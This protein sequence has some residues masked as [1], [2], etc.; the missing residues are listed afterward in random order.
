MIPQVLYSR[1]EK[2]FLIILT[3]IL[4]CGMIPLC[5]LVGF[6]IECI[7]DIFSGNPI[8]W[9]YWTNSAVGFLILLFTGAI[10][11]KIKF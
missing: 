1:R 7:V 2:M 10:K 8:G 11:I 5:A 4:S 6:G 3:G 9:G